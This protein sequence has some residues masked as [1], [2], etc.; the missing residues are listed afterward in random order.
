MGRLCIAVLLVVALLPVGILTGCAD[1]SEDTAE[2]YIKQNEV[3][4]LFSVQR[5]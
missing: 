5:P 4:L 1:T 2:L 3:G